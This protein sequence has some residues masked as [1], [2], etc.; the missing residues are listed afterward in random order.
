M[1][2]IMMA[3]QTVIAV[4]FVWFNWYIGWLQDGLVIGLVAVGVAYALTV[5]P[6]KISLWYLRWRQRSPGA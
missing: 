6:M 2:Y 3:I 1:I 5:W 4:A